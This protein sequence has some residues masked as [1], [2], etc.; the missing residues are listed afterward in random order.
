MKQKLLGNNKSLRVTEVDL[1]CLYLQEK[2]RP[3]FMVS[4]NKPANLNGRTEASASQQGPS[5]KIIFSWQ[6]F[7]HDVIILSLPLRL[8]RSLISIR[9]GLHIQTLAR[10]DGFLG[11]LTNIHN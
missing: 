1:Q 3:D 6:T 7:H 10:R 4:I 2:E 11:T 8:T 9:M 5:I